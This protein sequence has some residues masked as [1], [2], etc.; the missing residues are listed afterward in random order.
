MGTDC[1]MNPRIFFSF[2]AEQI[3]H[4]LAVADEDGYVGIY[5]TR[6]RLPSS[7]SSLGKSGSIGSPLFDLVFALFDSV[8]GCLGPRTG[9]HVRFVPV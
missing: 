9:C 8:R 7:S 5:D 1:S 4:L 3:S 2:Q 6:R